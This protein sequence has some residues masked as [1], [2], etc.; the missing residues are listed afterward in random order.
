[1][2]ALESGNVSDFPVSEGHAIELRDGLQDGRF[3]ILCNILGCHIFFTFLPEPN[4]A[5][6]AEPLWA[7]A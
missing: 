3:Y 1:M 2:A 7:I 6:Q 4:I 5:N